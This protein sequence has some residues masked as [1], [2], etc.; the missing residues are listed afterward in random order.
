M[1]NLKSYTTRQNGAKNKAQAMWEELEPIRD[2][3]KESRARFIEV[4]KES[5]EIWESFLL[6]AHRVRLHDLGI[7]LN[8]TVWA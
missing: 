2:D 4:T 8:E 1:R 6:T 7:W 3:I 5:D